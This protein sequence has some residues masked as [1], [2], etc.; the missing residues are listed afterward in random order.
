MNEEEKKAKIAELTAKI[1]G[2]TSVEELRNLQKEVEDIKNTN[3]ETVKSEEKDVT[4]EEERS[5]LRKSVTQI[6]ER[7]LVGAKMIKKPNEERAIKDEHYKV[8]EQRGQSLKDGKSVAVNFELEERATTVASGN[9]LLNKKYKE[10]IDESFESVSGLVDKLNS[11]PLKGGES[12][13]VP[14]EIGY[15]EAGYTDEAGVY[16]EIENDTDYVATGRAKITAYAEITNEASKLPNI[17]YQS[18]VIKRVKD[19]IR[20]KIGTQVIAGPGSENTIKGIYNADLKVLPKENG[21]TAD[22]VLNKIDSDTLNTIVFTYG[23]DES[24]ETEQYLILSKK[25]LEEFSKIKTNDGKFVYKI[26]RNGQ[27]G[28][29]AYSD[30]GLAVPYVIN[31]GCGS[32]S[33]NETAKDAFTMVYGSLTSYELPIFSELTIAESKDYKFKEGVICYRGDVIL[34]GTV[35][36]YKGFVRVKKGE[37][38]PTV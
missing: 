23:G 12:Y 27:I 3:V 1:D 24:V 38:T 21:K 15:D 30:G 25:D 2:A 28:T 14:F 17:N 11:I 4:L 7:E 19:S 26:T 33:K 37:T 36:K 18:L 34:G 9:L 29:I 35:S 16:H 31:S 32:L 8:L 20:K 13:S 5:L 22:I 6:E 10:N